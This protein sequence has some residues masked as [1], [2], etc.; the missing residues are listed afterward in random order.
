VRALLVPVKSFRSAKLRLAPVLSAPERA[1]LA[2]RLAAGV[3][4]AAG[5]LP[6]SVVCDDEEVAEWAG[7]HGARVIWTPGLGL[8]G[9]VQSGVATLASEG[10]T[11]VVVAHGDLP[12]ARA[13]DTLGEPDRV[14]LVPDLREDGTNVAVVP[15]A[16]GYQFSYGPGS[17]ERHRAEAARLGLACDVV[18]DVRLAADVD[19]PADLAHVG[20]EHLA[21]IRLATTRPATAPQPTES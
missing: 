10:M 15:A 7:S 20:T 2:R 6:C 5:A 1:E 9:A 16:A 21:T 17:F 19:V 14:T 12:N 11:L 8:S 4:A 13:L 18:R 3:L